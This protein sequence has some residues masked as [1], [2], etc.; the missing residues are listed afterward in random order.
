MKQ[1]IIFCF[2]L[3]YN[4]H[5]RRVLSLNQ[6]RQLTNYVSSCKLK[7]RCSFIGFKCVLPKRLPTYLITVFITSEPKELWI[8]KK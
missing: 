5:S 7:R 1:Y 4:Y 8:F 3:I 2:P 6:S